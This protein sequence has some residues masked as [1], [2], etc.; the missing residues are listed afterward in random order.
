M[1]EPIPIRTRQLRKVYHPK[2]RRELVALNGL[3]LD[4]QAGHV[5]GFIGPNG[6]GKSTTIKILVG[7][8]WQSAG[9]ARIFGHPV[10]SSAARRRLGYLPEIANYH[11]FM[12]V[13]ELLE[14][15]A[16]LAGVPST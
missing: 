2:T 15:H 10:G 6:A 16:Q 4:V 7:L 13:M 9:E 14:I 12:G 5:F 8:S 3:D 1:S 11:D